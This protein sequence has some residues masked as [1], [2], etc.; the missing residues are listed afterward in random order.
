MPSRVVWAPG[1]SPLVLAP[2]G[3]PSCYAEYTGDNATDFNSPDAQALRDAL[4]AVPPGGTVKVSGYCVGVVTQDGTEQVAVI[5]KPVTLIGGFSPSNWMASY[6]ITQET[7]LDA[8]SAGRVLLVGAVPATM[9]NLTI[10]RGYTA[11]GDGGGIFA[12][13]AL[14]LTQTRL[15][16]NV[17]GI[18]GG[19]AA[20]LGVLT[21]EGGRFENNVAVGA[22]GG[23]LSAGSLRAIPIQGSSPIGQQ[24]WRRRLC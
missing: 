24:L 3:F 22:V 14:T 18:S 15:V 23:G 16:T 20:V 10:A 21:L 5:T 4:T 8:A 2:A 12:G 11:T 6:P 9:A 7:T 1:L 13:D 17:A 19:G